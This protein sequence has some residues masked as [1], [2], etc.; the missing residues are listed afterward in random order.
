MEI[1]KVRELV[2][3]TKKILVKK[4]KRYIALKNLE[5]AHNKP[6]QEKEIEWK[7]VAKDP[8]PKWKLYK[9]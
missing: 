2:A 9:Y 5:K 4:R 8:F 6:K 3:E 1:S 7:Y